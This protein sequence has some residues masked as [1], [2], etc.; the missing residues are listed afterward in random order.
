[1]LIKLTYFKSS[2]KYYSEGE[3]R[4]V[5]TYFHEIIH[6]VRTML[7]TG[8]NPGLVDNAVNVDKFITLVTYEESD[9]FPPQIVI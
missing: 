9:A 8:N 7:A 5:K 3:Y 1:M 4:T 6:E 2:G